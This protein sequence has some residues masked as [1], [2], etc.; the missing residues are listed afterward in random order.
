MLDESFAWI[1]RAGPYSS[2]DV[3]RA[4][5]WRLGRDVNAVSALSEHLKSEKASANMKASGARLLRHAGKLTREDRDWCRHEIDRQENAG[6][7]EIGLDISI[8]QFQ[9]I[10]LSLKQAIGERGGRGS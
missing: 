10:A 7:R 2:R 1:L 4:V 3:V 6:A 8:P 5:S 9:G